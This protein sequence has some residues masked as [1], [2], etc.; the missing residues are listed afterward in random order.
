MRFN[1]RGIVRVRASQIPRGE[2][3]VL[4]RR[5][6]IG[7][8]VCRVPDGSLSHGPIAEGTPMSV[9]IDIECPPGDRPEAIFH[10]HPGGVAF[11]SPT[12]IRN[13]RKVGLRHL[14]IAVPETGELN[15]YKLKR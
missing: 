11:P 2:K 14:C 7:F 15:C 5:N 8:T 12:D 10:T 13:T 1:L 4:L 9:N 6:E 3:V